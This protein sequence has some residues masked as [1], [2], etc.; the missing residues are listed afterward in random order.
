MYH[1]ELRS[2]DY[3]TNIN[4]QFWN[5][6]ELAIFSLMWQHIISEHILRNEHFR[7]YK[8]IKNIHA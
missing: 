8:Q 2:I 7:L 4:K 5:I 6:Q 1:P 3:L